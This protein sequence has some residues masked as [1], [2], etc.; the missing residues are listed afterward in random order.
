MDRRVAAPPPLVAAAM[1]RAGERVREKSL[2]DRPRNGQQA[3]V[4]P[5][6][7]HELQAGSTGSPP[8]S[9]LHAIRSP[10][11]EH[12]LWVTAHERPK[13]SLQNGLLLR[14]A[15]NSLVFVVDILAAT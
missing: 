2:D 3:V 11:S 9:T 5:V 13:T 15:G 14:V 12:P 10:T 8:R 7:A 6:A 1:P 4:A